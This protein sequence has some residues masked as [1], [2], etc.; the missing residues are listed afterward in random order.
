VA[1][2]VPSYYSYQSFFTNLDVGYGSAI[3]TVMTLIILAVSVM[4]LGLQRRH[5]L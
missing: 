4:F 3:A 2:Q 1:T 5:A